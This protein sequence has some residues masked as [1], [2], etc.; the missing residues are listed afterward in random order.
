MET[1]DEFLDPCLFLYLLC[2]QVIPIQGILDAGILLLFD[3]EL[4]EL[5][6]NIDPVLEIRMPQ[7]L[8]GDHNWLI[9]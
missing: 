1:I 2:L 3:L 7:P 4:L 9:W 5:F 6:L 8:V